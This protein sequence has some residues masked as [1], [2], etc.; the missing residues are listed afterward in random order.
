M[1]QPVQQAVQAAKRKPGGRPAACP[2]G[3]TAGARPLP[4]GWRRW[5]SQVPSRAG[6]K[7]LPPWTAGTTVRTALTDADRC[8]PACNACTKQ[9]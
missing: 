2:P 7:R 9:A 8:K 6:G 3:L 4:S 1:A 5:E